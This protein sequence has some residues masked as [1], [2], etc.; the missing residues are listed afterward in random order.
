MKIF[1]V[2]AIVIAVYILV[3]Y[4]MI[5]CGSIHDTVWKAQMA[6]G[7]TLCYYSLPLLMTIL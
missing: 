2:L 5:L 4:S 7:F 6:L 3:I 1:I